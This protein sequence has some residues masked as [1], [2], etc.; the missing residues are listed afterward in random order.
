MEATYLDGSQVSGKFGS[1]LGVK[2]RFIQLLQSFT[3]LQ[4]GHISSLHW[5]YEKNAFAS[6]NPDKAIVITKAPLAQTLAIPF[7]WKAY[8]S[9]I[10]L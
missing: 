1:N 9:P 2:S 5:R 10:F 7:N 8:F 4:D 6:A 3:L